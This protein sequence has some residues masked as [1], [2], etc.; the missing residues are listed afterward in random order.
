[1]ELLVSSCL[2]IKCRCQAK[3][4]N[5]LG[6]N[7]LL[8]LYVNCVLQIYL[9]F[10]IVKVSFSVCKCYN[11]IDGTWGDNISGLSS[12]SRLKL[13]GGCYMR[14]VINLLKWLVI[15]KYIKSS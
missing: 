1:M 9:S 12:T 6:Q 13:V 11:P 8:K 7:L 2:E 4:E 3:I 5:F 14:W 10:K 15:L